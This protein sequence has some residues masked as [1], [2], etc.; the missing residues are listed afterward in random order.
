MWKWAD[1]TAFETI[2]NQHAWKPKFTRLELV[3]SLIQT[4]QRA[5]VLHIVKIKNTISCNDMEIKK[6]DRFEGF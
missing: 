3:L 5:N 6:E 1:Q 2:E 4:G